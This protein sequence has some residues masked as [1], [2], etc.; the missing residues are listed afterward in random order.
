MASTMDCK[1]PLMVSTAL[2]LFLVFYVSPSNKQHFSINTG[3]FSSDNSTSPY[4]QRPQNFSA[5]DSLPS[6]TTTNET[7]NGSLAI[8]SGSTA[9]SEH[10]HDRKTHTSA[11]I[12]EGDLARARSAI[13]KAV[14]MR[15]YTS[16]RV[17]DFI[18][19]GPIYRNPSYIEMEKTFKIWTYKEGE[20]PM[21]HSGPHS[22]LY[23]IGG[24]FIDE[25][26]EETNPFAASNMEEA[27]TFFLPFSV[28]NMVD[29]LYE[30]DAGYAP[31][32]R[33]VEDYVRVISEKYQYWNRSR[34]GDHFMVSC[35]DWAPIV[36]KQALFKNVIRVVCNANS[37]E[38]FN[39]KWDVSLPEFSLVTRTLLIST[40]SRETSPNRSILGFF[41]GG[42]HGNIRKI[43]IEQW[44][45][46]DSE[47]QVNE[48]LPKGTDYGALMVKSKFCLCPSGSEVASPRIVE[49]IH[50]SCVPVIIS[51]HY[52]LPFS[53]ILDWSQFSIQVPVDKI[54]ELKTILLAV[55]DEKYRRLQKRVKQVQLHFTLN[56]PAKRTNAINLVNL[57]LIDDNTENMAN[58]IDYKTPLMVFT[59]FLLLLV[60]YF[61]PSN[62]Q[63]F[64]INNGFI[65]SNNST[66]PYIQ[67]PQNFSA[68]SLSS[69]TTTN[70]TNNF[71]LAITS[72]STASSEHTHDRKTRTSGE[73]IEDD[74]ASA[75]KAIQKAVRTRNY[76]SNRVQDFIPRGPIYRNPYAFHQSYIEMEKT[77]KIWTYKEGE[78]PLVHN[79]PHS[80]LYSIEGHF[81]DEME[82]D[83]NPFAASN[84]DEAHIFFL[85]FSVTNMVSALYVPGS[86]VGLAPYI[87]VVADYVRVISEK[88]QYWNRS[89]GGDHFMVSCH[90]W[91]A[92]V[93]NQ[94][95]DE[96]FRNVIRAVCNA[97]S[98]ESFNPKLDVS[99]PELSLVTRTL[100]ISTQSRK[101]SP[102]RPILGFFAGGAHGNIRKILIEQWKDKDSELQVNEYLPK[103]TDYGALMVRSR[104]CLCPS[105][106]EVASPRIVEAIHA[107]CVPVIISD[108][109]V[110]PF[111]DILDWSQFSIQ[112]P[113]D[114]IPELKAILLA[115]PN[116]RYRQLQKRVKQVQR[117]FTLN[118][119]A[120][121][122]DV[123][124]MILHS[125]WLRRLNF[126]LPA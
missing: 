90:D 38:S 53:D 55:P 41:A 73:R 58:T 124:H 12:I 91:A 17:Q 64:G 3:F 117:H 81:I 85:P 76:T 19:R 82:E 107:S 105:G 80:Y 5:D 14:R 8:T 15:N 115:I 51:D 36:T 28:T 27:H 84:M 79:G 47:L 112:V 97:N 87:H 68:D 32:I 65:S 24:H 69:E 67:R 94:A 99:L 37:S 106:Y 70:E 74:L 22:Y 2:L 50:A 114:K 49:A 13:Q 62:K 118:R 33:V 6:K 20:L 9:S 39:P 52:V 48:Y 77:F 109:Y 4:I 96:L 61:S 93:T 102:N 25:M 42:A 111:S 16:N 56:R 78:L 110:L 60:F 10:T 83:T 116:K 1:T 7:N 45:D 63:Q 95:P 101:T 86:R 122:F 43:L 104:F 54:P 88:Y 98:S 119:P 108:H 18:P 66:S 30:P 11:E 34:G 100:L 29:V 26:E 113:V 59:A 44:K 103:G 92:K 121:R 123:T 120:K 89:S 57:S 23:S 126:H 125:V 21:V 46:K 31:Y 72:E 40:Q 35:H 71:S 75:R